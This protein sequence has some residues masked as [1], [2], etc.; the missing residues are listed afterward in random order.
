MRKSLLLFLLN[1]PL[2]SF[3]QSIITVSPQCVWR[4]GDDPAWAA[5]RLAD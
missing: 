1:L 3:G 4:T 2:V 5:A